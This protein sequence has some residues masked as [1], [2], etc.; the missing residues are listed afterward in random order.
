M[1]IH[2]LDGD[3]AKIDMTQVQVPQVCVKC[4]GTQK[5]TRDHKVPHW[6]VQKAYLLGVEK[7]DVTRNYQKMCQPHNCEKGGMIDYTDPYVREYMGKVA[8]AI[9]K[10]I[11]IHS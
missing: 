9:T 3:Q 10:N 2:S 1:V 6:L 7:P 8:R 11:T 5:I 4:E